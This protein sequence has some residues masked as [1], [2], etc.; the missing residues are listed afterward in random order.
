M[1]TPDT[2]D[3]FFSPDG[4]SQIKGMFPHILRSPRNPD[5]WDP[6]RNPGLRRPGEF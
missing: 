1:W 5:L 6:Q 3:S 2:E 4:R